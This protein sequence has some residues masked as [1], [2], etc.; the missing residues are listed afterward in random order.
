[1][2]RESIVI[3][4]SRSDLSLGKRGLFLVR[5]FKIIKQ[6][7]RQPTPLECCQQQRA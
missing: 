4:L 3:K 6:H 1:M 5:L 2:R 7:Q